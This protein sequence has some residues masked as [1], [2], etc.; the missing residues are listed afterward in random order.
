MTFFS[1]EGIEMLQ[2]AHAHFKWKRDIVKET[3]SVKMILANTV[4][5]LRKNDTEGR[6]KEADVRLINIVC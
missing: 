3:R 6:E 2:M 4:V 1:I 5:G